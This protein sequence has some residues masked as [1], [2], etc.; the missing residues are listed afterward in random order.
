MVHFRKYIL[1]L[2]FCLAGGQLPA[3]NAAITDTLRKSQVPDTVV[4]PQAPP[5]VIIPASRLIEKADSLRMKYDFDGAI[6]ALE[7]A[8][9]HS[10]DSIEN[11]GIANSMMLAQ[12][13]KNM[14]GYCSKPVVVA[15]Q[16]FSIKDFFLFYPLPDKSWRPLPNP[17]DSLAESDFPKAVY[18]PENTE[19][20]Y[21]SAKDIDGIRNIYRTDYKDSI[22]TVPSLVNEQMTSLSDEIFPMLSADGKS[23]YFSSKGLYGM[24]G[25]DIY[26]SNWNSELNDWD[27]PINMGFPYSSPYDDFLF[28]NTPDGRYSMFASNRETSADSVYIYVLEFDRMPVR[29]SIQDKEE[30]IKIVSLDPV[31]DPARIDNVSAVSGTIPDNADTRRY[32]E[33]MNQVRALRK[34]IDMKGNSIDESRNTLASAEPQDK[35]DIAEAILKKEAELQVLQDSLSQVSRQLQKIEMEFLSGGI[36][37]DPQ[38][39]QEEADREVVGASSAYTFSRSAMGAPFNMQV[40]RPKTEFDYSFQI[41]PV[42]RFAEN[43]TLPKG[44]VY[45]IQIFSTS[46]KVNESQLKGLS[47]VFWRMSPSL[48]YTYCAGIFTKYEDV[49]SNLNKV[50]KA[51]FRN[52]L[53]VAFDNGELITLKKARELE[54]TDRQLYHIRIYTSDGL[55]LGEAAISSVHAITTADFSKVSENG[56]MYYILGPYNSK[57]EAEEVAGH[58]KAIGLSALS[59]SAVK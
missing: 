4:I 5:E 14:L 38:K 41:L 10:P 59:I 9:K 29:K 1:L 13:A 23:L 27:M 43:N 53:I 24:G 18:V 35:K 25:Y 7:Q 34:M 46:S 51:G 37:I 17:L 22:W 50:K 55:P 21:Y 30:L 54:K 32:T 15:K 2:A 48:R 36:M 8:G 16:K 6:A 49:L 26:V 33:K 56:E 12:N 52:A 44:L 3:Q 42:G 39:M 40:A 58:L 47:P 57:A 31:S 19:T 45:Q 20:L 28:I 11:I